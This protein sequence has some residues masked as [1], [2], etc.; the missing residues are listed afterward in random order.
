MR[1]KLYL[2]RLISNKCVISYEKGIF[3][4]HYCSIWNN[5]SD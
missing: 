4:N 5:K 1:K 3:D 2:C